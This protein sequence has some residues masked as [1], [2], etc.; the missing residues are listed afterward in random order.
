MLIGIVAPL[1]ADQEIEVTLNFEKA[2][3]ITVK[4]PV[5]Q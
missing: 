2:G 5:Q 4:V 1:V 3:A